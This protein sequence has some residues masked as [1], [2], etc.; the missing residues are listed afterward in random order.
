M[1]VCLYSYVCTVSRRKLIFCDLCSLQ[2]PFRNV[3]PPSSISQSYLEMLKNCLILLVVTF[4]FGR[5]AGTNT[6][7]NFYDNYKLIF[8][9][10]VLKHSHKLVFCVVDE[11][12]G[13]SLNLIDAFSLLKSKNESINPFLLSTTVFCFFHNFSLTTLVTHGTFQVDDKLLMRKVF[14]YILPRLSI[15][16][17]KVTIAKRNFYPS[18][19]FWTTGGMGSGDF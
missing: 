7:F 15:A 8:V 14:N 4:L 9:I 18:G 10:D 13:R 19:V 5:W 3:Y 1:C 16:L 12:S 2:Q 6:N 17:H 11:K